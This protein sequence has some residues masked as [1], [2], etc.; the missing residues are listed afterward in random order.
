MTRTTVVFYF[1]SNFIHLSGLKA[2]KLTSQSL[3]YYD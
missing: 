3:T 1:A 2:C